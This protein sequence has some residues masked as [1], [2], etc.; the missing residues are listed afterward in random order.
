MLWCSFESS[1]QQRG[2]QWQRGHQETCCL[3]H[4]MQ[5]IA[6]WTPRTFVAQASHADTTCHLPAEMVADLAHLGLRHAVLKPDMA[7]TA[8][9]Q[10]PPEQAP[11]S[12]LSPSCSSPCTPATPSSACPYGDQMHPSMTPNCL[13]CCSRQHRL[14]QAGG[15]TAGRQQVRQVHSI[16]DPSST[17]GQCPYRSWGDCTTWNPPCLS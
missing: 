5:C 16:T 14:Q 2:G 17:S 13:S 4:S 11:P 3:G 9:G 10:L 15:A 7:T 1:S 8:Q 6:G 12:Y